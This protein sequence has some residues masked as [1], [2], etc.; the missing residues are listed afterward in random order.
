M[1]TIN[2]SVGQNGYEAWM[3]VSESIPSDYITRN[4][5]K[6]NKDCEISQ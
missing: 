1:A 3:N 2:L 6:V 4:Y 5:T